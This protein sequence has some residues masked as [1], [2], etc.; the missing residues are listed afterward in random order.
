MVWVADN[1]MPSNMYTVVTD[2]TAQDPALVRY[3]KLN[4]KWQSPQDYFEISYNTF[5]GYCVKCNGFNYLD[6]ISYDITGDLS[7][8]RD[9][10]LLM[11][12]VEKFVV[13]QLRSNKFYPSIGTNIE[14]LVGQKFSNI[15]FVASQVT[16][17]ITAS[18]NK[19]KYLQQ[20]YILTGRPVTPGEILQNINSVTATPDA[21]DPTLL[22]VLVSV[23]AQS[24]KTIEFTQI[25]K[26]VR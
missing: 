6:D 11:Q 18:L 2:S 19:F 4:Q 8:A 24:G 1:M 5:S 13:T 21:S 12:N 15:Q 9:E 22:N 10:Q 17:Q 20:Q 25:I 7:V 16:S 23:S 26:R 3:I 14:S